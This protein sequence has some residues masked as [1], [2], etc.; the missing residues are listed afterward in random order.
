MTDYW[1]RPQIFPLLGV[2]IAFFSLIRPTLV[3]CA[4]WGFHCHLKIIFSCLPILTFFRKMDIC[5]I[6]A[7][8]MFKSTCFNFL[9]VLDLIIRLF[10]IQEMTLTTYFASDFQWCCLAVLGS[11]TIAQYVVSAESSSFLLRST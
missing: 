11:P 8:S 10:L 4:C 2:K 7:K 1:K 9:N 5:H 3:F 6:I